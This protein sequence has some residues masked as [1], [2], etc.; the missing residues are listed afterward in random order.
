MV[1][2]MEVYALEEGDIIVYL[3]NY[4]KFIDTS[5]ELD[6]RTRVLVQ[7]E[8]GFHKGITVP[9]EFATFWIVEE[10]VDA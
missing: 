2:R 10:S 5:E 4:Y 7:D 3:G 1:T 9:N 8:E 6:G